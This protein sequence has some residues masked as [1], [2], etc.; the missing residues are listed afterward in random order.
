MSVETSDPPASGGLKAGALQA[1]GDIVST[2]GLMAAIFYLLTAGTAVWHYRRA[3]MRSA[4][5]F[6]LGGVLGLVLSFVAQRVSHSSF[7]TDPASSHGDLV[8]EELAGPR[9]A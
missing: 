5:S 9:P 1:L 4:S 2:L 7:S 8:D 3:A 6:V